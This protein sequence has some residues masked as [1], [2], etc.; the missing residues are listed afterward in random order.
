ME[1][2]ILKELYEEFQKFLDADDF[3][4][5]QATIQN[6]SK[7]SVHKAYKCQKELQSVRN[8]Q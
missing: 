5:A 3:T 4:N 2:T 6:I 8:D 1:R 7:I